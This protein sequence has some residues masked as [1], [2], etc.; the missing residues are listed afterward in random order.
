MP[1]PFI[2]YDDIVVFRFGA[3]KYVV[4]CQTSSFGED[5]PKGRVLKKS[6]A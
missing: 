3:V 4:R 2:G 5:G 6:V 1:K